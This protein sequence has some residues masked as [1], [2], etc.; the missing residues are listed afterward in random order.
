MK[1]LA[2]F[3]LAFNAVLC[4][5]GAPNWFLDLEKEFPSNKFVRAS[6]EGVSESSAK[7]AA[8][9]E[10]ASFF[11]QAIGFEVRSEQMLFHKDSQFEERE[12]VWRDASAVGESELYCVRFAKSYFDKRTQKY[13]ACAY[14]NK[15]ELLKVLERKISFALEDCDAAAL[16]ASAQSDPLQKIVLL[17][18]AQKFY[19]TFC[20]LCD[21]ALILDPKSCDM[22]LERSKR[23]AACLSQLPVLKK[24]WPIF[25]T[26]SGDKKGRIRAKLRQLLVEQGFEIANRKGVYELSANIEWNESNQGDV[27]SSVPQIQAALTG[28]NG[29][30]ASFAGKCDKVS[31]YNK[32]TLELL[33][34]V[35]LESLLD[36]RFLDTLFD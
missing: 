3:L 13:F 8:L 33:E 23:A 30:A 32:E 20:G 18:K 6:G 24:N 35:E 16:S 19:K 29:L 31:A 10:L 17:S 21:T 5:A 14:I 12:S 1:K 34:L 11:G 15:A 25:V 22:F 27:F 4:F 36:E 7:N 2:A 26:A 28:N 9:C